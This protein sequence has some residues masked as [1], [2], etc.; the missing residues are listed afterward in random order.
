VNARLALA[1]AEESLLLFTTG[2][3]EQRAPEFVAAAQLD[4]AGAH[5]ALGAL[6]GAAEQ[7]RT[8]IRLPV[9][10]RTQPIVSRVASVAETLGAPRF[11][12]SRLAAELLEEIAVFRA[13]PAHRELPEV[14]D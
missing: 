3:E 12:R 10:S 2:P 6:D 11:A 14:A 7:L 4:R 9:E 13:Y 5:L 1:D 8:V